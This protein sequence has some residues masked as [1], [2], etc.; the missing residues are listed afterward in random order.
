LAINI[1]GTWYYLDFYEKKIDNEIP[2][3]VKIAFN[4]EKALYE[5]L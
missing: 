1:S 4:E 2:Y 5:W 3:K